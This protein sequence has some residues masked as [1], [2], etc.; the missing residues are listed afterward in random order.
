MVSHTYHRTD[1][2]IFEVILLYINCSKE[3]TWSFKLRVEDSA[4]QLCFST[5]EL[6]TKQILVKHTSG[7][8][9]L[10]ALWK[11][12]EAPVGDLSLFAPTHIMTSGLGNLLS[13][14]ASR[15][16]LFSTHLLKFS[17]T[18]FTNSCYC[19]STVYTLRQHDT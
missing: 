4:M 1:T 14:Q 2:V 18:F 17:D 19:W 10:L 12:I 5:K 8:Y 9:C 6:K 15:R 13:K 7:C 11:Y 3:I 16:A